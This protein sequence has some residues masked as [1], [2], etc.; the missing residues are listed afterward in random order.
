MRKVRFIRPFLILLRFSRKQA[1]GFIFTS[2]LAKNQRFSGRKEHD[3]K[4]V[5]TLR[6]KAS[7][8]LQKCRLVHPALAMRVSHKL[9]FML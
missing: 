4:K 1:S 6:G 7:G 8:P 3:S 9:S 2:I 5:F